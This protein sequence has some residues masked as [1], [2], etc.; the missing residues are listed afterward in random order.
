MKNR[1]F[2]AVFF[3][4][5]LTLS[6]SLAPA[7]H[8]IEEMDVD[9]KAALLID[10]TTGEILYEKNIHERLYPASLTKV[11]SATL[12]LEAIDRGDL[13]MEQMVTASETAIN[14]IPSGS[15]TAGIKVGESL[16]V[17]NLLYCMLVASA[18]EACNVLAE[19]VSGSIEAFVEEMNAKAAALGCENTHFVN[20]NG[21]HDDNHYTT[22]WDLYLITQ[23]ALTHDEFLAI[24]DTRYFTL[25]A[26]EFNSQRTYYTTNLLLS[27]YRG[28]GYVY[29]Y[30]HGIKTGTTTPAGNCLISLAEKNGRQL[31]GVI[32][33]AEKITLEDG[34]TKTQSFAE[35]I[36]LFDWGFDSFTRQ[37]IIT[38]DQP[39]YELKVALSETD[40]VVLHPAQ[41][42]ERLLPKDVAVEDLEHTFSLVSDVVDAPISAGDVLGEVVIS[43][44][45]TVYA[46]VPLLAST[47][48]SASRLLV[49]RRDVSEFVARREV[50]IGAVAVLVLC[51]L[52]FLIIKLS[53]RRRRRYGR[54]SRGYGGAT[55]HG[56]RRRR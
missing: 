9:A 32:L 7:A 36:R 25:P 28:T 48:V 27:P 20:T 55:Y 41:D 24:S 54:G 5:I 10:P 45:D 13:T 40:F 49:F 47:D 35:M 46:T 31:L 3:L 39:L 37:T 38:S 2:Y 33:G 19:A 22:A 34:S 56:R 51:L 17:E 18:N 16:S 1:R 44:G 53:G 14:S 50:R 23:E 6:L 43:Y 21:L 8:A 30:A 52:L 15:S 29:Q 26:T 4:L 42:V 11:M 12:V